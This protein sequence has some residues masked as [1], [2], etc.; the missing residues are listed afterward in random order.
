MVQQ[1]DLE[2]TRLWLHIKVWQVC[3]SHSVLEHMSALPSLRID[4]PYTVVLETT[5]IIRQ[6]PPQALQGNGRCLVRVRSAQLMT[7]SQAS[8]YRRRRVDGSGTPRRFETAK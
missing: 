4:Y 2:L 1:T 8:L 5:K 7:V 6:F 3:I